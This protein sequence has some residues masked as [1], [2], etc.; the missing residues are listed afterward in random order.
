MTGRALVCG[1]S[2]D[3]EGR[4]S[5]IRSLN[6]GGTNRPAGAGCVG[7]AGADPAAGAAARGSASP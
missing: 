5:S 7:G 6:V 4:F 3:D 2:G 1:A